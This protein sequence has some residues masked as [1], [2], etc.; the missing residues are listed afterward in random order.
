MS[1]GWDNLNH[2]EPF[3]DETWQQVKPWIYYSHS[4]FY[5]RITGL[6]IVDSRATAPKKTGWFYRLS[7]WWFAP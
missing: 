4:R 6:R 7:E 5:R 3:S 2:N 1:E